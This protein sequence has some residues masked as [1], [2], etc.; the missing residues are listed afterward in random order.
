MSSWRAATGE[1]ALRILAPNRLLHGS[2]CAPDEFAMTVAAGGRLGWRCNDRH[3]G[4]SKDKTAHGLLLSTRSSGRKRKVLFRV[5]RLKI[6]RQ[7]KE[8]ITKI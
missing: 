4:E 2:V 3:C 7:S 8:P 6:L 1:L 5:L